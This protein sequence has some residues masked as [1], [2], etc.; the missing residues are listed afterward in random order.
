MLYQS[1]Q[2]GDRGLGLVLS[3]QE[4]DRGL[5]LVPESSGGGQGT[6]SG[7]DVIDGSF[8]CEISEARVWMRENSSVSVWPRAV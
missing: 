1:P 3:P 7:P 8:R 6:G 4:G 5:G 2:E